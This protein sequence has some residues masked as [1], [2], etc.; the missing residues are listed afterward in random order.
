MKILVTGARGQL[1]TD[2]VKE[3]NAR[4]HEV[5]PVDIQELDITV[6]ADVDAYIRKV[7]PDAVIHCAAYTA[8][9]AAE[10]NVAACMRVNVIGTD[11]IAHVCG[12]LNI[13][14][15]YLSTDYVFNGQGERPWEPDDEA[16]PINVY[17]MSKYEGEK[18][19]KDRVLKYYI[20][21][22]SWV[23]GLNG[24]NLVKT[25]LKHGRKKGAV[26]V[27]NDQI[28]SPT[29]TPDHSVLLADMIETNT[30]GVYHATNEGLCSWYDFACE[31]FKAAGMDD[32]KV[33]PLTTAEYPVKAKRP[34]NSRMSKDKLD[35]KGFKRLPDWK[36]A[37]YR[38]INELKASES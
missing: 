11:N 15:L 4:G 12:E 8:V 31:I 24:S 29:Y 30:Y 34:L 5:V 36:D 23:F 35:A 10:D 19:V 2:L 6:F 20:V 21:R 9:D 18:K 7:R 14:M 38:F 27:V 26:S 25:M 28:G 16:D 13:R 22:I 37:L 17:G 32:V 1:G 3:L 33:T